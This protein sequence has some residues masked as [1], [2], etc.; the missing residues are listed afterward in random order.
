MDNKVMTAVVIG[1]GDRGKTVYCSMQEKFPDKMKIVAAA[2]ID[3]SRLEAMKRDFDIPD[4]NLFCDADELLKKPKMADVAFICTLDRDHYRYA[5]PA[6]KKG[7]QLLLEKPV[8]PDLKECVEIAETAKETGRD[9][10]VCHVLRYTAFYRKIK[11]LLD[12]GAVGQI[13]SIQALEP[14]MYWHQAHSFVRGNWR[15]SDETSPMIL[16]KCCH[17]LDIFV[18]LT[19]KK[20]DTVSSF[21]SLSYFKEENV[22]EG[23]ADRCLDCSVEKDCPYSAP[24]LYLNNIRNGNFGWP[25]SV[26]CPD[27]TEEKVTEALRT[28]PY[29]RCVFRCDNNVVDHQVVN[30]LMEDGI[31]VNFTMCAFTKPGGRRIRIMGTT[32]EIEGDFDMN[33]IQIRPFNGDDYE[34]DV[35]AGVADFGGHGGGDAG[36]IRDLIELITEGK[37]PDGITSVDVSLESHYAALAAEKS[38]LC[39]GSPVKI[40]DFIKDIG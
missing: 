33:K 16:Q 4:E 5:I 40:R 13:V 31:T 34:I 2:D 26:V 12:D 22:P 29:G 10:V 28:G 20:V 7:Y 37:R 1:C 14:V 18:W 25:V 8:S 11:D 27:P 21:G 30:L 24:R 36:I 23:S 35:S 32:G 39:G 19:G 9:V 3:K 38:R 17:D 15:R 6:M